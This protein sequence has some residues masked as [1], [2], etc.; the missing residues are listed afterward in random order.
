MSFS[1]GI[2]DSAL[3]PHGIPWDSVGVK[4]FAMGGNLRTIKKQ[5]RIKGLRIRPQKLFQGRKVASM[6]LLWSCG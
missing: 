3:G 5:N 4:G 6:F 2:S 1:A